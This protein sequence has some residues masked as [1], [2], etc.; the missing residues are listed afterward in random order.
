[1]LSQYGYNSLFI[2]VPLFPRTESG[3]RKTRLERPAVKFPSHHLPP[4]DLPRLVRSSSRR[5]GSALGSV[6]CELL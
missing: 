2:L 3:S 1:M 4:A 6:S 5:E